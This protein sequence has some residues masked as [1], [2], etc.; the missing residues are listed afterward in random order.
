ML[1]LYSRRVIRLLKN[2][3]VMSKFDQNSQNKNK[4]NNQKQINI[5]IISKICF[6]RHTLF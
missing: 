3:N 4:I 2:S 5:Q 1:H 6:I